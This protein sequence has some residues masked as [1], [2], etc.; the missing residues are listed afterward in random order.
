MA[1]WLRFMAHIS[2]AQHIA[3][4]SIVPPPALDAASVDVAAAERRPPL[5]ADSHDCHQAWREGLTVLLASLD[6]GSLPERLAAVVEGLHDSDADALDTLA[7][8]F[9]HGAV[10]SA[11]AAKVVLIAAALQ[12][13]FTLLASRLPAE[14]VRLLPE[15]GLC[16][17]CGSTSVAGVI[18]AT[19]DTPGTRYLYCGLCSTAWNHVRA[20][21]ITCG[22]SGKVQLKAIEG[23]TDVVR[24]ETCGD[25]ETYSKVLYQ[26]K[27]TRVDPFADD[28]ATLGLDMLVSEAG[29]ARHAPNPLLLVG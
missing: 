6:R 16:P 7:R 2:R 18:T 12:V 28:L 25:C 5:A 26:A 1:E 21:C 4:T 11:E 13:Y 19:G 17:C 15:R 14:R 10:G 8:D 9:L 29:F 27:D 24:A 22:G 20:V 3:A 23:G